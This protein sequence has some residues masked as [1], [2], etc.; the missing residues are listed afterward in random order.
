MSALLVRTVRRSRRVSSRG[1]GSCSPIS[2]SQCRRIRRTSMHAGLAWAG[3]EVLAAPAASVA[4][5]ALVVVVVLG[6]AAVLGA[7]APS[8]AAVGDA[9]SLVAR[10]ESA[11]DSTLPATDRH[12]AGPR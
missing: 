7:A 6:S 3:P 12:A 5:Q 2:T 4:V 8:L 11:V 1:S 10:R 9:A